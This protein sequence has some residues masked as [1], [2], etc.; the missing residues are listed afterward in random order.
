MEYKKFVTWGDTDAAGIVFYPN[1]YKWMDEACHHFFSKLGFPVSKLFGEEKVGLPILEATCAFKAPLYF[2]DELC[3]RSSITEL[4]D[5]VFKITH[6]FFKEGSQ[7]AS[8]YELRAWTKVNG[9][10][11]KAMSI[12][13]EI[14]DAFTY[15]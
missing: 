10:Q 15:E 1:Y 5:K 13:L 7:V 4:H 11:A 14:R 6:E 9:G 2:E 3:I 8:G 12:P